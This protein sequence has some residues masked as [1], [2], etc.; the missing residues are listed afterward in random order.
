MN[1]G[2]NI[3][4]NNLKN[5]NNEEVEIVPCNTNVIV[6]FYEENPYRYIETSENGFIFGIESKTH[7]SSDSGETEEN[8]PGIVCAKV[9]AV[10]PGCKNVQ[11][12]EDIFISTFTSVPVPFR[13]KG[14]RAITEQNIIC[15][16][17]KNDE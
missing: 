4:E 10:G 14:Y 3:L 17:V 16:M 8:E 6:K 2:Q 9:I 7:K 12:G 13:N 11:V 15:R 1:I 5:I